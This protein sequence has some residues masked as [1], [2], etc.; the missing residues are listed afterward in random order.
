MNVIMCLYTD[1]A[2]LNNDDGDSSNDWM[3]KYHTL[4]I[5]WFT[6]S[7]TQRRPWQPV[8]KV[9][10]SG[11]PCQPAYD[12]TGVERPNSPTSRQKFDAGKTHSSSFCHFA[13]RF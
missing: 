9:A 10:Q 11:N 13:I 3:E 6:V 5:D 1:D 4:P 2:G 8:A 7:E 12:V